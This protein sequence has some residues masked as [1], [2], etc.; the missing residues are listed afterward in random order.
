MKRYWLW[1]IFAPL[2][3]LGSVSAGSRKTQLPPKPPD[4][5]LIDT[6]ISAMLGAWQIGDFGMMKNYYADDVLVVSGAWEPALLG[7]NNYVQAY[8]RQRE[9]VQSVRLDRSNTF[10][11][12]QGNFAW[13]TYQ[14]SFAAYVDGKPTVA[15]GQ[16]T[17][18]FEKRNDRWL[19]VHN[20]TSLVDQSPEQAPPPQTPPPQPPVKPGR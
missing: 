20:H 11:R 8:M 12:I 17:L 4:E 18:I 3:A 9:R 5:Q 16:T 14:W 15:R 1:A 13:S 2:L 10:T 19:I 6:N 7:W